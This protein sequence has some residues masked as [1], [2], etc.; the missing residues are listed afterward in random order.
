M[1]LRAVGRMGMP[2][3]VSFELD[4]DSYPSRRAQTPRRRVWLQRVPC[5]EMVD[6]L[7]EEH[8][9]AICFLILQKNEFYLTLETSASMYSFTKR[10][11]T[12]TAAKLGRQTTKAAFRLPLFVVCFFLSP[13]GCAVKVS[14]RLF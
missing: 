10:K 7:L 11:K 1:A 14:G 13:F 5:V 9:V 4:S 12:P 8:V 3:Y 2:R 6:F